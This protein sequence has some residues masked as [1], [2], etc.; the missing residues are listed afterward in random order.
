MDYEKSYAQQWN[1]Y[2]RMYLFTT[3]PTSIGL[4]WNLNPVIAAARGSTKLQVDMIFQ[5]S[6]TLRFHNNLLLI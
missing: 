5:I 4:I 3:N 1:V 6:A 2:T